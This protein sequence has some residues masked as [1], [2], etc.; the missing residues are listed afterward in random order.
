MWNSTGGPAEQIKNVKV[1][2]PLTLTKKRIT[3]GFYFCYFDFFDRSFAFCVLPSTLHFTTF[4]NTMRLLV[5]RIFFILASA[6]IASAQTPQLQ[7][8]AL[9][10]GSG[11]NSNYDVVHAQQ[12]KVLTCGIYSA[13]MTIGSQT[14]PNAGAMD[15]YVTMFSATG[16]AEWSKRLSGSADDIIRCVYQDS[17]GDV[18]LAGQYASPASF[19]G[20]SLPYAGET[21]GFLARLHPDGQIVWIKTSTNSGSMNWNRVATDASGNTI[22]LGQFTDTL[23]LGSYTLIGNSFPNLV[24]AKWNPAGDLLWAKSWGAGGADNGF[25]LCVAPSGHIVVSADYLGPITLGN[26]SLPWKGLSDALV[27]QTDPDGNPVWAHSIGGKQTDNG[28]AVTVAE[29][30]DVIAAGCFMDTLKVNNTTLVS[31]GGWDMYVFRFT[32]TGEQVWGRSLGSKENDRCNSV[33][34]GS[35]DRIY[36]HGWFQDTLISGPFSLSSMGSFDGFVAQF[37]SDGQPCGAFSY[38]SDNLDVGAG[39]DIDGEGNLVL[40]GYFFGSSITFG[41]Q[42]LSSNTSTT[43]YVFRTGPLISNILNKQPDLS[44]ILCFQEG[45]RMNFRS[46]ETGDIEVLDA[47]GRRVFHSAISA[48]GVCSFSLP[49]GIYRYRFATDKKVYSSAFLSP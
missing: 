9:Y 13:A 27:F 21:D 7:W 11:Q 3:S 14:L 40:A 1:F 37:E 19:D 2:Q 25:E 8:S 48:E 45:E 26:L 49:D 24:L 23:I 31:K 47:M 42:S 41:S 43:H 34:L 35:D 20:N 33:C 15:G 29:N 32:N 46:S 5:L 17:Q 44:P 36:L 38:G 30:G 12:G 4:Q 16:Q 39:M 10:G 6:G 28:F 22:G 18:F